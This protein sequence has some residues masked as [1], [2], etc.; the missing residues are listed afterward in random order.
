MGTSPRMPV[1]TSI[2][3]RTL[4]LHKVRNRKAS[5]GS[6]LIKA[7]EDLQGGR[8]L[9]AGRQKTPAIYRPTQAEEDNLFVRRPGYTFGAVTRA[10]DFSRWGSK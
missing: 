5:L 6:P 1:A 9:Q 10:V 7:Q 8:R 3:E 4:A 2:H